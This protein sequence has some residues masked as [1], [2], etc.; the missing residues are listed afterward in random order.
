MKL[1]DVM[2]ARAR[3]KGQI[4][5]TPLLASRQLSRLLG[6]EVF[7]KAENLQKTGAFKARGVLNFLALDRATNTVTTYSSG[8]HG[9][10]LAWGAAQVGRKAVI[11][12]PEDAS[13]AK[14]A[15]VKGYGGEVRLAGLS[16]ADRFQACMAYVAESGAT[17]VPPFDHEHIIAGQGTTMLEILEDLPDPDAVLVPAGGG[18]LLAGNALA[19]HNLRSRLP[20]IACEPDLVADV[21]ASVE[22]GALQSTPYA[23]TIA[24]GL[25][26]LRMGERNWA[27][28]R[29]TVHSALSCTEDEIR[30]AMAAYASFMKLY[31]EPSGATT[32][33]CLWQNR[34]RFAGQKVVL[35]LSG[36]NIAP[37]DWAKLVDQDVATFR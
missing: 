28:V 32:L 3:I 5:K 24:D 26:N 20:V 19:A 14:I 36:G 4:H 10:A 1:E 34:A 37:W 31:V 17:V 18:G 15:A 27:I 21:K 35:L 13:P 25:R 29:E 16:S 30:I 6:C 23:P 22:S 8:N 33:A 11:F 9:G 2:A 12:M 7:V